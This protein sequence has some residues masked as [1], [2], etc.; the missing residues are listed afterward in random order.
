M[1]MVQESLP[2]RPRRDWSARNRSTAFDA[3]RYTRF[4]ARMKR[5]LM[6]SAFAVIFAVLAFFMFR[7]LILATPILILPS[8]LID[9]PAP[10]RVL[11]ALDAQGFDGEEIVS[12]VAESCRRGGGDGAGQ[13]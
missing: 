6:F 8:P 5:V 4:V 2:V 7:S 12:A 10:A 9:K 1:T 11:P 3:Q 13:I